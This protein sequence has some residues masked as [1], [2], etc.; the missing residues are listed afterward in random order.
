MVKSIWN[1]VCIL[2]SIIFIWRNIG[3]STFIFISPE[4]LG[5]NLKILQFFESFGNFR[6]FFGSNFLKNGRID[7]KFRKDLIQNHF[8]QKNYRHFYLHLHIARKTRSKFENL[9][10]FWIFG[11]FWPFFD[12]F[13]FKN[14]Q[15]NLKL[16][17]NVIQIYS[18]LR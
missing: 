14:G 15:I 17:M 10:I 13:F 18:N 7:L 5:Q 3:I 4:K 16:G 2:F 1:L 9:A 8:Y 6:P 12:S 11:N